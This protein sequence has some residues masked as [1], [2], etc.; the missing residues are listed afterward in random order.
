M[1]SRDLRGVFNRLADTTAEIRVRAA[2]VLLVGFVA[3]AEKFGWE[4]ILGAFLAGALI[5]FFDSDSTA[6]PQFRVKLDAIGYG[7]LIP[8]FFVTSGIRLDLRGL[9]DSPSAIVRMMLVFVALL[10]ARGLPTLVYRKRFTRRQLA[11]NGLLMATSLPVIVSATQ[12]GVQVQLITPVN[13]AALTC[14]GVLSVM[15]FPLI[16]VGLL[17]NDA[18]APEHPDAPRPALSGA[19]N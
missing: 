4:S 17:K 3:L 10:V 5:G 19:Q 12:I 2:V 6:H 7:F 15:V 11:A 13:A 16:T 8:A 1:R 14:A 18:S 9:F